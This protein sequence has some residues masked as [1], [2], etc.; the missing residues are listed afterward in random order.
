MEQTLVE[1]I[2][3]HHEVDK[4]GDGEGGIIYVRKIAELGKG[5]ACVLDSLGEFDIFFDVNSWE[6]ADATKGI[7]GTMLEYA[8]E[9]IVQYEKMREDYGM[10]CVVQDRWDPASYQGR[11]SFSKAHQAASKLLK[12]KNSET[13]LYDQPVL[14]IK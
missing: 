7:Y 3:T 9:G 13:Q 11:S 12:P 1:R 6:L 5:I 2:F 14:Y 10:L 4:P 8:R